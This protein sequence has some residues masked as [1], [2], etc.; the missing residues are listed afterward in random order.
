MV[1]Y[2]FVGILTLMALF[3]TG[4]K[5][6]GIEKQMIGKTNYLENQQSAKPVAVMKIIIKNRPSFKLRGSKTYAGKARNFVG[7]C[8]VS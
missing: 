5:K 6:L 3:V 8:Q 2:T 4:A 1:K 7:E